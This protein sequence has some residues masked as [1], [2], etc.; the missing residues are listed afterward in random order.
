MAFNFTVKT[1]SDAIA[2]KFSS[3]EKAIFTSVAFKDAD[4]K[5][6]SLVSDESKISHLVYIVEFLLS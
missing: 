1:R 3:S 4:S 2:I 6:F 5:V